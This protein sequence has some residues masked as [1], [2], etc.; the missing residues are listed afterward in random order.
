MIINRNDANTE[1]GTIVLNYASYNTDLWDVI[2]I[3]NPDNPEQAFGCFVYKNPIIFSGQDVFKFPDTTQAY[4]GINYKPIYKYSGYI[5][6]LY[7]YFVIGIDSLIQL[8]YFTLEE[9]NNL[10]G[11]TGVTSYML[12]YDAGKAQWWQKLFGGVI[13]PQNDRMLTKISITGQDFYPTKEQLGY[14]IDT[15][16]LFGQLYTQNSFSPINNAT[17][18]LQ[19]KASGD[20]ESMI[21]CKFNKPNITLSCG[22]RALNGNHPLFICPKPFE[23]FLSIANNIT[24]CHCLTVIGVEPKN[25]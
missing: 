11:L 21:T 20:S 10:T 13:S 12:T 7:N 9:I 22:I 8:N 6:K 18:A 3:R 14:N 16:K 17:W 25:E 5:Y 19:T 1:F 24:S 4:S 15:D 23:G 2:A